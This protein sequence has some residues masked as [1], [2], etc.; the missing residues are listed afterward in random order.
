[1]ME[2][3]KLPAKVATASDAAIDG[4]IAGIIS[5]LVML[6]VILIFESLNGV[7]PSQTLSWFGP[8]NSQ[9]PIVGGLIHTAISAIYG[10]IFGSIWYVVHTSL[11]WTIPAWLLGLA[12]SLAIYL[13]GIWVILPGINSPL[14]AIPSW[15]FGLAHAVFGLLLGW[16]VGRRA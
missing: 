13:I 3:N 16:L 15:L 7:S 12:F 1:M 4:L 6:V 5:G 14:V 2:T 8:D 11:R 9:P 10:L